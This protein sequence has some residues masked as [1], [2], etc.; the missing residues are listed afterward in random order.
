MIPVGVLT[1]HSSAWQ[2]LKEFT[3]ASVA[4]W[5]VSSIS[6]AP[7]LDVDTDVSE[8]GVGSELEIVEAEIPPS[9]K[10]TQSAS[11]SKNQTSDLDVLVSSFNEHEESV[12]SVAWSMAD[13]WTFA[14]LSFDGRMVINH[15]P[16]TEKYKILL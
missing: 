3:D 11:Y 5:R 1:F 8:G 14:S 7:L 13:A 16:S 2:T 6:S 9:E 4:L 15:V 10:K 12:Y